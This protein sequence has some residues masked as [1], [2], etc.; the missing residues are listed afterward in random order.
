MIDIRSASRSDGEQI[1]EIERVSIDTPWSLDDIKDL[2][3][4]DNCIIRVACNGEIILG[5]YSFCYIQS[6]GEADINNIAVRQNYRRLGIGDMLMKDMLCIA[7]KLNIKEM[8]LEVRS[9]NTAART[10]Y[11]KHGFTK[12]GERKKYYN[13]T[14]DAILYSKNN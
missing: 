9:D 1:Y 11:E 12:C 5:Y 2:A 10:L 3:D 13:N 8:Y 7:K 14:F 4:K 6:V